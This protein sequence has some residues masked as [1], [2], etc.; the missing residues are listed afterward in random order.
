MVAT[1]WVP[2]ADAECSVP[3]CVGD[4]TDFYTSYDH[5][6]N[7]GRFFGNPEVPLNLHHI[8]VAYHG[9]ASSVVISGTPVRR[10]NGQSKRPNE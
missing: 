1:C 10:P 9:R 6:L 4:F 5:A 8:P 3:T 2:Q 7:I